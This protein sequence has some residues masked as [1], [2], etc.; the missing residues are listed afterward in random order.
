MRAMSPSGRARRAVLTHPML[1]LALAAGVPSLALSPAAMAGTKAAV[2]ATVAVRG[3]ASARTVFDRGSAPASAKPIATAA[4]TQCATATIPQAER[5]AT[6]AGEMTAVLG[7]ARMQMRIDLEERIPG[8]TQYRT[9][10]AP[11]LGVWH[12]STPGVKVFTHIQQVSNLSAPAFY[13]GIVRFRWVNARG[14]VI[15]AEQLRTARCEQPAPPST[16]GES[17]PAA[18]PS[19]TPGTA[20]AGAATA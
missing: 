16:T 2:S 18:A 4:L 14:R 6:F 8:E 3:V 1:T 7:S 10:N 9:V 13:R 19:A 17:A 5:S 12:T 11:A 15:K 20:G